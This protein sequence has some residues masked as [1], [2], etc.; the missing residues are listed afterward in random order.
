M[1]PVAGRP[2]LEHTIAWLRHH[3]I[4]R[5]A[6][7]LHHLPD[8]VTAHFGDGSA[9]SISLTYSIEDALLGTAGGIKRLASFL[10]DDVF[11]VHYGDVLTD[12]DL[13]GL[14]AFHA[15]RPRRPC[16]SVT[17]YR[18]TN[19]HE[20]G[21]VALDD[22][23]RIVRFQEKPAPDSVFD[24][25]ANAGVLVMDHQFLAHVPS[26]QTCDLGRD[27]FP[28]FLS[29]DVPMYGWP[30][31]PRTFLVDV[32]TPERYAHACRN[33]PTPAA[34]RFLQADRAPAARP[35]DVRPAHGR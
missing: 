11:V 3:G 23:A 26:D 5:I 4:D 10:D 20:C 34:R 1:V 31:P 28:R 19:P 6:M 7:N 13:T 15:S 18:V 29:L 16:L 17:L 25:L 12:L 27:V 2:L 24:N 33:W 30:I 32:G 14:V 21:I 35:V 9:F 22:G 8:V